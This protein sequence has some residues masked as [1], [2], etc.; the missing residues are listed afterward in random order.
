MKKY[1]Y[2]IIAA[3]SMALFSSFQARA[4]IVDS[5]FGWNYVWTDIYDGAQAPYS[6][7]FLS[8]NNITYEGAS[9]V[10]TLTMPDVSGEGRPSLPDGIGLVDNPTYLAGGD[11]E[12][13]RTIGVTLPI[14]WIA[15]GETT[16]WNRVYNFPTIGIAGINISGG[17]SAGL[18]GSYSPLPYVVGLIPAGSGTELDS[19]LTGEQGDIYDSTRVRTFSAD[20][21]IYPGYANGGLIFSAAAVVPVPSAVWLFVSGLLGL[22]GV[23]RRRQR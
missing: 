14:D 3:A 15:A 21:F 17:I 12:T 11:G 18:S 4:V 2:I 7:S 13:T 23:A 22:V 19:T 9:G 20:V 16:P 10:Q 8:L 5:Y 6:V 1:K